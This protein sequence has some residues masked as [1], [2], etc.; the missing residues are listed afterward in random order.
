MESRHKKIIIEVRV[1][2]YTMR[3][4][5]P[6]VPWTPDE[7]AHDAAACREEGAASFH[8]HP[9]TPEG[10]PDLS[11]ETYRTIVAQ[12][13]SM[14]DIL[15]QPTLGA[16]VQT[17]DPSTRLQNIVHLAEDGL[18]PDFAPLD[19]GSTNADVLDEA[20]RRFLSENHVYQNSTGTL[21]YLAGGL[22]G[23]AIKPYLHIWNIPQLRL[24]GIFFRMGLL[25]GPLWMGL[26]HGGESAPIYQPANEDGLRAYLGVLPPGVPIEWAA[27]S[28]GASLLR[29]APAVIQAGGHLSIGIGDHSYVEDGA[30]TNAELVRQVVKMAR[31]SGREPATPGEAKTLLAMN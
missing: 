23:L 27:N 4:R 2:E 8:F 7:I 9:R 20:G 18:R 26:S 29:F 30:P 22:K 25:E 28:F 15:I 6:H 19:M 11:Y 21:R 10:G 31:D 14:S 3:D 5:N 12:V 13:R 1:N 17:T 16:F 24:A